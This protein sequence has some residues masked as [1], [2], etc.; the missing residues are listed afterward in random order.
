MDLSSVSRHRLSTTS[1]E[2]AQRRNIASLP[3]ECLSKLPPVRATQHR[4]SP[5][6]TLWRA[7][8]RNDGALLA[9]V[10]SSLVRK[11]LTS[12]TALNLCA[13]ASDGGF[14]SK[15]SGEAIPTTSRTKW[16]P[17]TPG[18]NAIPP[19]G[20][21]IERATQRTPPATATINAAAMPSV[22]L[23]ALQRWIRR[24]PRRSSKVVS[25]SYAH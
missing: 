8:W 11:R 15:Q 10:N 17:S 22:R 6:H 4:S 9:A 18:R 23:P 13:S 19:T 24:T 5:R 2:K 12:A 1:A 20:R 3:V 14:G 21:L 16:R 7:Q 25:T